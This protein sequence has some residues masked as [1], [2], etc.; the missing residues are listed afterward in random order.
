MYMTK[1]SI[2]N[3][4]FICM[5]SIYLL[6]SPSLSYAQELQPGVP[7][8]QDQLQSQ[9]NDIIAK[10][11]SLQAEKADL[12]KRANNSSDESNTL[13]YTD[14]YNSRLYGDQATQMQNRIQDIDNQIQQ[15]QQ[16]Q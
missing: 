16:Q 8:Q 7:V 3:T 14:A 10:I 2:T 1:K 12:Q 9:L 15:L 4:C 11:A 5:T 6:L 13:F